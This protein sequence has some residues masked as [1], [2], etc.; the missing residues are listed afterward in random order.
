MVGTHVWESN[1]LEETL[2]QLSLSTTSHAVNS[3]Q[4]MFPEG[5]K[6]YCFDIACALY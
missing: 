1:T 6:Y 4:M 2:Y 5:Y 3:L